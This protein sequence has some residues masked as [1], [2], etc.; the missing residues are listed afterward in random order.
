MCL[1]CFLTITTV[2]AYVSKMGHP[3]LVCHITGQVRDLSSQR[4]KQHWRI[5]FQQA[6]VLVKNA[7]TWFH[8]VIVP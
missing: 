4:Q 7:E 5:L 3:V 1:L 8:C 2:V 6:N